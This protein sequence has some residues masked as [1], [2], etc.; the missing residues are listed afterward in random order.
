MN[1]DIAALC[2]ALALGAFGLGLY[3]SPALMQ[4]G[5]CPEVLADGRPLVNQMWNGTRC[6]YAPPPRGCED[7]PSVELRRMA[8]ARDA[9][10]KATRPK[11]K[12]K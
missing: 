12:R 2:I 11:E 1:W 7:I 9:F 6:S 8:N 4:G 5:P 3:A 10:D